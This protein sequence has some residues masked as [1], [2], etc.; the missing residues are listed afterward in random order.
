MKV[1][2]RGVH[3]LERPFSDTYLR[4]LL[5]FLQIQQKE[6]SRV[7]SDITRDPVQE[8]R[9]EM[10]TRMPQLTRI[11]RSYPTSLLSDHI[12]YSMRP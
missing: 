6:A 2:V 4:M 1:S 5:S 11:L 3:H 12:S 9:L 8:K 7:K 10:I